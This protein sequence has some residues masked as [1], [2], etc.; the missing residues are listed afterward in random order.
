MFYNS[1]S[2]IGHTE[3]HTNRQQQADEM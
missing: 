3:T 2:V 1:F